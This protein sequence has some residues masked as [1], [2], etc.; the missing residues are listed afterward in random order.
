MHERLD[1]LIYCPDRHI[2][3]DGRTPDEVGVGG[4]LTARVRM[5]RAIARR[6]HRVVHVGNV[7]RDKRIDGVDYLPLD[8][9]SGGSF[10]IAIVTTSGDGLDL[11]PV[12]LLE[13]EAR[14]TVVWLQGPDR[15]QSLEVC[16]Y[17]FLYVPSEFIAGLVLRWE[18][19]P[20]RLVVQRN[21]YEADNFHDFNAVERDEFQLIYASHPSKGLDAALAVSEKLRQ[22]DARFHLEV[23]G[24]PRLWG[25]EEIHWSPPPGINYHGL[26]GQQTLAKIMSGSGFSL[27]LQRREEPG[28]LLIPEAQRAGSIVVA[29][30]VGVYR[31]LVEDDV[32]GIVIEGDPASPEVRDRAASRIRALVRNQDRLRGI[33]R[34]ALSDARTWDA[35]ALGWEDHWVD[36]LDLSTA[37]SWMGDE[38][39]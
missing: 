31:E 4:G 38:I 2:L 15:P 21:G 20:E 3:Y 16:H 35:A 1:V 7:E 34:R 23:L 8:E 14:L 12:G 9:F 37:G 13:L 30:P 36:V 19:S 6:G 11:S 33:R 28:A 25:S 24:G 22:I 32:N 27:Q 39:L 10:D 17:D 5:G 18:Q 29:S 26:V